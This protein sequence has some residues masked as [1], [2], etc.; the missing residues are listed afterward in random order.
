MKTKKCGV[1]VCPLDQARIAQKSLDS[2]RKKLE[3]DYDSQNSERMWAKHCYNMI[4]S[5][6]GI[7][8]INSEELKILSQQQLYKDEDHDPKNSFSAL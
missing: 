3:I 2:V 6:V 8:E 1:S 7:I 5:G 4:R